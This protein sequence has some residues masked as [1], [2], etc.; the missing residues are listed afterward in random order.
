MKHC[1]AFLAIVALSISSCGE[2][3]NEGSNSGKGEIFGHVYL[4]DSAQEPLN[5]H[6]GILV[7]ILESSASTVTDSDGYWSFDGLPA[8]IYDIKYSKAGYSWTIQYN[9]QFV[10]TG[11]LAAPLT[12]LVELPDFSVQNL[13][14]TY[15]EAD[16]RFNLNVALSP[17]GPD[18]D[19]RSINVLWSSTPEFDFPPLLDQRVA[20]SSNVGAEEGVVFSRSIPISDLHSKG[21]ASGTTFYLAACPTSNV[22]AGPL[23][24]RTGEKLLTSCKEEG[25]VVVK[26]VMP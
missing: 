1:I 18:S 7:E 24:P 2:N 22:D 15:D 25:A 13:E 17:A 14:V 19:Y 26:L 11:S 16:Q 5:D 6:S 21:I 3:P 23:N 4:R 10:G 12:K 9:V 8:G 20:H